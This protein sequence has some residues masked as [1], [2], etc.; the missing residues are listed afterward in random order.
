MSIAPDPER[1][2][3]SMN[4]RHLIRM[5]VVAAVLLSA[6]AGVTSARISHRTDAIR[7]PSFNHEGTTANNSSVSISH[8]E[9]PLVLEAAG[10][11]SIT[12]NTTLDPG[13]NLEVQ[14][15]A[16]NQFFMSQSV[17][18]SSDGTFAAVFN[19]SDFEPGTEFGAGRRT[20]TKQ[21]DGPR[22]LGHYRW[23]PPKPVENVGERHRDDDRND[24]V[25]DHDRNHDDDVGDVGDERFGSG[26]NH[27]S[28]PQHGPRKGGGRT[29]RE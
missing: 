12:G 29:D 21:F 20:T 19:F 5:V 18:V 22:R 15:H 25:H 10:D 23:R 8:E 17:A 13:T 16:T 3:F 1:R 9:T 24:D 2:I 28:N 4:R 26:R 14:I 11:Q 27:H 7:S 6:V